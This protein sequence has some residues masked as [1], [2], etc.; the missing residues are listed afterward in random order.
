MKQSI[1]TLRS[2][3]PFALA[4]VVVAGAL[5]FVSAAARSP[6]DAAAQGGSAAQES[7][8]TRLDTTRAA[9]EQRAIT[10]RL[11]SQETASW[12]ERKETLEDSIE[13][14]GQE[15]ESLRARVV[16]NQA[17]FDATRSSVDELETENERLK[18]VTATLEEGIDAL[19]A[20]LVQ[21]L[22]RMPAV[23]TDRV[24]PFSQR[25][26]TDPTTTDQSL[27]ER[28]GNVVAIVN[29][30]DKFNREVTVRSEV[31][32][33]EDGSQVEVTTLYLGVGQAYYV[34]ADR[35]VAGV[36]TVSD[37]GWTWVD[38]PTRAADIQRAIAVHGT[39]EPAAYVPLPVLVR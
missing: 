20:R 1:T 19:E 36:G 10:E 27:A 34:S 12:K 24:R 29:E 32:D 26:P 3:R 22:D 7:V 18:L 39:N 9:L 35:S 28:Y 16:Q 13:L 33:L 6:Q 38:M 4:S 2:G 25:I 31:R 5:G 17:T 30:I 15:I 14:V 23:V 21:L 8:E 11:I 37:E